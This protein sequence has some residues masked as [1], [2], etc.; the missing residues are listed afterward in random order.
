MTLLEKGGVYARL[1]RRQL[2]DRPGISSKEQLS[3]GH[4]PGGEFALPVATSS[5]DIGFGR[6]LSRP[7]PLDQAQQ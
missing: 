1:V 2:Q 4:A 7:P 6:D 3:P 5:S